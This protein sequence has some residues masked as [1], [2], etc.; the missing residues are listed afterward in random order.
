MP[1]TDV[2]IKA[3]CSELARIRNILNGQNADFRG[4]DKQTDT[5]FKVP[6]GRLKLREGNIENSLIFYNRP[7]E[8]GP[9][10]TEVFLY[11]PNPE[12]GLKELLVNALGVL[13]TVK[14]KREIYFIDNVKFH[15]DTVEDL[16]CF[17]EIEAIDTTGRFGPEKLRRQ[18]ERYMGLLGIGTEDLVDCSYSDMLMD[19][20]IV[21]NRKNDKQANSQI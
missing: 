10:Q 7:D 20:R 19:S 2:E 1:H 14:K 13:V 17:V 4:V 18:C 6:G 9:K 21:S 12:A 11:H 5:Y 15:I 16:G 8:P 3:R